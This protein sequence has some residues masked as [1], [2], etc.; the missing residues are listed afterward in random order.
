MIAGAK[1]LLFPAERVDVV[2]N[3]RSSALPFCEGLLDDIVIFEVHVG[4]K[5]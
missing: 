1:L 4:I 3:Q 2:N 5:K